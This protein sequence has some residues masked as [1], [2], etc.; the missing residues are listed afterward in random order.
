MLLKYWIKGT[1][2]DSDD[3]EDEDDVAT[4]DEDDEEDNS[5]MQQSRDDDSSAGSSMQQSREDDDQSTMSQS[6]DAVLADAPAVKKKK[7]VRASRLLPR[8]PIA[9]GHCP[10]SRRLV[11]S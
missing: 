8:S 5:S 3:E 7:K 6:A 10:I 2:K 9:F 11:V 4:S 1:I